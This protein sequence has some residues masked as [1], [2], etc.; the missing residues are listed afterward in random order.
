MV[1]ANSTETSVII[2]RISRLRVPEELNLEPLPFLHF[3]KMRSSKRFY[4]S[5]K[6]HQPDYFTFLFLANK[7]AFTISA[8]LLVSEVGTKTELHINVLLNET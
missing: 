1:A 3:N 4:N 2:Y 7:K 5:K 8:A 6:F